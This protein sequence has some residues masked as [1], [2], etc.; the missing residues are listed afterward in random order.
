MNESRCYVSAADHAL[1]WEGSPK[2][3][4]QR[5]ATPSGADSAPVGSTPTPSAIYI[6][7]E[8]RVALRDRRSGR[9]DRR[10]EQTRGRRYRLADRRRP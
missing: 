8:R 1:F 9:H 7:P 10:W 3:V 4:G 2:S 6:G 5:A